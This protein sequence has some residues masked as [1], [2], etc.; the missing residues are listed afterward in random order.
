MV[1]LRNI[2][3]E[4]VRTLEPDIFLSLDSDILL[5][6]NTIMNLIE[7]LDNYDAV[8]GRCYMYPMGTREPSYGALD[9]REFIRGEDFGGICQAGVLMGIKMM[10]PKAYN[11]DYRFSHFGEDIGWSHACRDLDL[12]LGWDGR[13]I[14][15]HLLN[16]E[17]LNIIDERV[18]F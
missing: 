1:R 14:N 4:S 15:K 3:L 2:L 8:G 11:V 5:H 12:T 18:G 6:P 16:P 10:S 13:T 17:M 7:S 9:R